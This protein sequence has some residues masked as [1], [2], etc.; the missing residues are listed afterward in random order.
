MSRS[1]RSAAGSDYL[2]M[3]KSR[4]ASSASGDPDGGLVSPPLSPV[5]P[6]AKSVAEK[7]G[8]GEKG[9][10]EEKA[11]ADKGDSTK[12]GRSEKEEKDV[13]NNKEKAKDNVTNRLSSS[14]SLPSSPSSP[15]SKTAPSYRLSKQEDDFK[16][17]QAVNT[18]SGM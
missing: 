18:V 6:T 9:V 3:L 8:P 14:S 11:R 13:V 12:E 16:G 17:S 1:S 7:T 15:S 5:S 4:Y 10:N 2:A